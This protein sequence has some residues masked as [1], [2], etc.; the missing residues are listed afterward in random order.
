MLFFINY[1]FLLH[2]PN[3]YLKRLLSN[4]RKGLGGTPLV[5]L[6]QE[7]REWG[8]SWGLGGW[9]RGGWGEPGEDGQRDRTWDRKTL[10]LFVMGA[11]GS[12]CTARIF[13]RAD[14]WVIPGM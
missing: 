4:N 10:R 6:G 7:L 3:C 1:S 2:D 8:C 11:G 13:N 9:R 5:A 12:P 14:G